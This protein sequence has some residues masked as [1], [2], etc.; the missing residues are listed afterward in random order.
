EEESLFLTGD[1]NL[2]DAKTVLQ[3]RIVDPVRF[4][5][6]FDDPERTVKM[7]AVAQLVEVVAGMDIDAL[8]SSARAVAEHDV[9]EGVR[10]RC[11]ELDLGVE[12]L[13]FSILDVHAPTEVHAAFR[14]VASAVEDK[15]TA[16]NVARRYEVETVNLARGEAAREVELA[17][18]FAVSEI[19][20]AQGGA[21]SLALRAEAFRASPTG[22]RKRLYLETM[23]EVLAGSRKIIRPG[24]DGGGAVDLWI[25]GTENGP[26]LPVAEVLRG[27]EV[28]QEARQGESRGAGGD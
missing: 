21:Q 12:V 2:V 23:E 3:Y 8:Y 25:S 28:R 10:G 24:W 1:E 20:R 11:A 22:N 27:S 7:Q 9:L 5:Y 13:R 26:P 15:R 4:S 6:A 16:I 17:R 18:G 19:N 14:D